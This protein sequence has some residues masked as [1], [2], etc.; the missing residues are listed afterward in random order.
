MGKLATSWGAQGGLLAANGSV[1]LLGGANSTN[2]VPGVAGLGSARLQRMCRTAVCFFC[3]CSFI[4]PVPSFLHCLPVSCDANVRW[5]AG[6]FTSC[7]PALH[8]SAE[9]PEVTQQLNDLRGALNDLNEQV[10]GSSLVFLDGDRVDIRNNETNLG[11]LCLPGGRPSVV[12]QQG[13]P[14]VLVPCAA[15]CMLA[16]W[17]GARMRGKASLIAQLQQL[18]VVHMPASPSGCRCTAFLQAILHAT[19]CSGLSAA[20]ALVLAAAM[21]WMNTLA[22]R[23]SACWAVAAYGG[24]LW[25]VAGRQVH[26]RRMQKVSFIDCPKFE[27]PAAEHLLRMPPCAFVRAE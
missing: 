4:A 18:L 8:H 19:P 12:P 20:R 2:D 17:L 26:A 15:G 14:A 6:A 11:A 16:H 5:Q 3:S 9:D 25:Q 21:S 13:I 1:V 24:W 10:V 7:P 23:P 22:C 27:L